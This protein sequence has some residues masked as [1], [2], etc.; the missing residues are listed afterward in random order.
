MIDIILILY[1]FATIA[2]AYVDCCWLLVV[3]HPED[4]KVKAII[5]CLLWPLFFRMPSFSQLVGLVSG[6]WL[7]GWWYNHNR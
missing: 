6:G 2:V 3:T 7:G 5:K 4:G 1:Y